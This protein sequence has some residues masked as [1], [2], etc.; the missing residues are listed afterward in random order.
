MEQEKETPEYDG[1]LGEIADRVEMDRLACEAMGFK[2]QRVSQDRQDLMDI[3]NAAFKVVGTFETY[4]SNIRYNN[5]ERRT[6]WE[7]RAKI[8]GS[9]A[10][11]LNRRLDDVVETL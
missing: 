3:V 4:A 6:D 9:A 5:H 2:L 8:Y 7:D 11:E 10:R 1:K